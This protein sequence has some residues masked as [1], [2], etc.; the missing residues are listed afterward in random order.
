L[1]PINLIFHSPPRNES[2][3]QTMHPQLCCTYIYTLEIPF[4]T[5]HHISHFTLSAIQLAQHANI[6]TPL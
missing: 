5:K 2:L 1:P 4:L 3:Q 6:Q